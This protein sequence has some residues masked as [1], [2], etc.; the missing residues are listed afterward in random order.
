MV[1]GLPENKEK[2]DQDLAS[3]IFKEIGCHQIE[4]TS[5]MRLGRKE[6]EPKMKPLRVT[7]KKQET[8][9]KY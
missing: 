9:I 4:I 2:E 5:T 7:H 3:E 8:K 1:R 6:K